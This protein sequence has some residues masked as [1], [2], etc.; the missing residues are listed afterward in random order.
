MDID[1]AQLR[2]LEHER[3]IAMGD[4]V[5][6]IERALLMAYQRTDGH[7]RVARA[8]MDKKT[9]RVTIW[10]REEFEVPAEPEPVSPEA[11]SELGSEPEDD[12]APAR[13][14]IELGPEFDDTPTD[15]G[16]V[17]AAT[18]RQ[19]IVNRLRE[20]EDEQ[21]FGEFK[22]REGDIVAGVIQQSA[23]SRYV[24]VSFG[25]VE[26]I[27]GS[28]TSTATASAAMWWRPSAAPAARRSSSRE[29]T[30][31]WCASCLRWKCP[32]WRVGRWRLPNSCGRRAIGPRWPC[33]PKW[34]GSTPR[35]R[36]SGRW[37]PGCGLL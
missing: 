7:Y 31:T 15:F 16:R 9:G 19:V 11:G 32:K 37:G 27:L 26:G 28:P 24:T 36:A 4:L 2:L 20:I 10:A 1:P 21:I 13:P 12:A 30:P 34:P 29:P 22:G 8:E 14:R 6:A 5:E 25:S 33:I 23:S 35:A 18:A 3:G 17:A